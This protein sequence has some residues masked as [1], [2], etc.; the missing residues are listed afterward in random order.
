MTPGAPILGHIRDG[1]WLTPRRA[2]VYAALAALIG[3]A[4]LVFNWTSGSGL[5]DRFDRPIGTDFAGMWTAGRMLLEGDAAGLFD[6]DKHFAYQRAFFDDPDIHVYGW[7]Y[8]PFFLAIAALLGALPY[9]VA[10]AAWQL[11]TFAFYLGA[12]RAIAPKRP[13]ALLA[14]IGFPA[15]FV[16]LGHGHNAFLTA[17]LLGFGLLLLD[18]RPVVAGVLIGL[19][20]YKP[21]FGLVLPLVLALGGRW[22]SVFSAT[23]TVAAMAGGVTAWLGPSIWSAFLEGSEFTRATILEQGVTGWHKI[24]S[25]F[26][27]ARSFGAPVEAAYAVQGMVTAAVAGTLGLLAWR[28]VDRDL[29]AAATAA[30]A[31]LAT[32]YSLDYD[33]TILGVSIAFAARHGAREGVAPWEVSVLALAWV[34]PLIARNVMMTTA[35]PLGALSVA[36]LFAFLASRALRPRLQTNLA[37][38]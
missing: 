20:A 9:L 27:A 30:G 23:A 25:A 8:P 12:V 15:V 11:T 35:I 13:E 5:T 24:Q 14:A 36:L 1:D 7:H 37:T 18:R 4:G 16:T 29:L 32:P 34:T 31:L 19:L 6:P 21:Q 2:M 17:G 10:L 28:R 38:A 26:S 33:M 3:L 22:T